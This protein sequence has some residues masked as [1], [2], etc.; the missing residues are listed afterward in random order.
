VRVTRGYE[1]CR[2]PGHA[3]AHVLIQRSVFAAATDTASTLDS[4]GVST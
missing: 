3:I 2:M 4:A 1:G